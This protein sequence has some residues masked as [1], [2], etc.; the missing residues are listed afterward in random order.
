MDWAINNLTVEDT[1]NFEELLVSISRA[2]VKF[3]GPCNFSGDEGSDGPRE[4]WRGQAQR[5]VRSGAM[6]HENGLFYQ[7]FPVPELH[8]VTL[9]TQSTDQLVRDYRLAIH[10][11]QDFDRKSAWLA[12]ATLEDRVHLACHFVGE[13]S[14]SYWS[15]P[16]AY[17]SSSSSSSSTVRAT[18]LFG[19]SAKSQSAALRPSLDG[20]EPPLV[21][22]ARAVHP[23]PPALRALARADHTARPGDLDSPV[24]LALLSRAAA[25]ARLGQILATAGTHVYDPAH[26]PST[27]RVPNP[28]SLYN[29]A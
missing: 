7:P 17:G 29:A 2:M 20:A 25:R 14:D 12:D 26:F 6:L 24:V 28:P 13:V 9:M 5:V 3:L 10:S 23:L 11:F 27:G 21:V 19:P 18:T 15:S 1:V 22:S 8:R 4:F 16:V